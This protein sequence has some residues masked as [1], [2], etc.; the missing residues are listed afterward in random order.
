MHLAIACLGKGVSVACVTYQDKF[1]G[2]FKHFGLDNTTIAPEIALQAGELT[3]FLLQL[4]ENR[5]VIARQIRNH[6]LK[7]KML[8]RHNFD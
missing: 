5:D 4:L 2:L 1:E 3:K 7:V 8:A 6:I